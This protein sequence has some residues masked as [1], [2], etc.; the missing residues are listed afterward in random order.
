MLQEAKAQKDGQSLGAVGSRLV[1]ETLVGFLKQDPNSF[2]NNDR[3]SR[4]RASGIKLP[5]RHDPVSSLAEM[6]DYTGLKKS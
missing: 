5:G 2:L 6:I 4:V 3:H 1:A